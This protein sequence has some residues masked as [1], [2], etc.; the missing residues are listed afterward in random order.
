MQKFILDIHR[1]YKGGSFLL[2]PVKVLEKAWSAKFQEQSIP[3]IDL[4]FDLS[5]GRRTW[6]EKGSNIRLFLVVFLT[7]FAILNF[8]IFAAVHF[9]G[10]S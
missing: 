4:I 5:F 7:S 3:T 6:F 9:F 8:T 2:T 10:S 1:N